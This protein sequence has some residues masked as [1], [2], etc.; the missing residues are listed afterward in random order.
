[1]PNTKHD[2]PDA[3]EL[4]AG[5]DIGAV[6]F[7]DADARQ[8]IEPLLTDPSG[9]RWSVVKH[10][11][12]R[13]VYRREASGSTGVLYLKHFHSR[14]LLHRLQRRIGLSET[15]CEMRFSSYL[16][17]NNVPVPKVLATYNRTGTEWMVS[18]GIEPSVP[19]DK[20]HA[21]QSVAGNTDIRAATIALAELVGRMH[22]C[23]VLHRD[24]H[25]GNVL[26]RTVESAGR[27]DGLVLMDLHR[28]LRRRRLSRR[29]RAANL[30]QLF[31]D[32]RLWTTRSQRIRFLR[33]Y[34]R[35]A[36]AE[37]TLRGWIRLIELFANR[38]TRRLYAQRD[39]R[40]FATNRYFARMSVA[41]RRTHVILASKRSL[42]G[43]ETCEHTF[44]TEDWSKAL[45]DPDA[46]FTGDDIKIIKDSASSY[47]VQRRL[48]VGQ[49]DIDVYVKRPRRKRAV[50]WVTDLFRPSRS[51]RSFYLGHALLGRHIYTALPL[52]AMEK[53]RWGFLV[54][55]ILITE[56]V[57]GLHLN[58]FLNRYLDGEQTDGS[59][60][61]KRRL[62][63]QVLR[64]LGQLLRRLHEERFAHRDLKASNLLVHWDNHPDQAPEVILVDLD[65]VNSVR[66]VTRRQ[67]FRGLMRLNVSLL[68]CPVVNHAGRLRML[69]GYLRS[70]GT[71]RIN[72]KPYWRLLQNWST[73]KIRRQI[74]SRQRRQ[75]AQRRTSP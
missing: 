60:I 22:A 11:V 27:F 63:R 45:A 3:S 66:R 61:E 57:H 5:L 13:T 2:I 55:S 19:A 1:M 74:T 71:G 46:L 69:L 54:D 43:S 39:R 7:T 75:K 49:R 28:M 32:R 70:P 67:Q 62:A 29:S 6:R 38:H 20:W 14:S 17:A 36:G 42:P 25:C 24:L 40:I 56:Q 31:H 48:R 65:G 51:L 41:G 26:V 30:A 58:K 10:N 34:L 68:E 37:G 73:R 18:E 64:K 33:H 16:S 44:T 12:S 53:R 8:Q 9:D 47:I 50:R 59:R 23:G 35:A 15:R 4:F 72:F 52:A 21:D